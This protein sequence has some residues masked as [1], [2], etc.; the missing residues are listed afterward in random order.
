MLHIRKIPIIF[1]R[2]KRTFFGHPYRYN[3]LLYYTTNYPHISYWQK[4]FF[5]HTY[6]L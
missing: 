5:Y 3:V 6:C 2:I 4:N 1:V